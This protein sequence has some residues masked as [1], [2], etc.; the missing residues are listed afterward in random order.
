MLVTFF[1]E[2][3]TFLLGLDLVIAMMDTVNYHIGCC[4]LYRTRAH[5]SQDKLQSVMA[6]I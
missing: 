6:I 4:E 5:S 2:K 3:K 1:W